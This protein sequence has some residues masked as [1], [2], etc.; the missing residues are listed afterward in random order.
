MGE[1]K[2]GSDKEAEKVEAAAVNTKALVI[3]IP[4]E[5]VNAP[6]EKGES[7]CT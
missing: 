6:A 3:N 2:T 5:A 7:R 1:A 4:S